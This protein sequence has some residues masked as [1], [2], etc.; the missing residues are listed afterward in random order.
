MSYWLYLFSNCRLF[1]AEN[2][3]LV[4]AETSFCEKT[5]KRKHSM[6]S[7]R[8]KYA[9]LDSSED[10]EDDSDNECQYQT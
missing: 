1:W 2:S 6:I 10:D 9:E 3:L 8:S 7:K 5:N 4:L